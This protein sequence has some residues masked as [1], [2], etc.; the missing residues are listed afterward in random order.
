MALLRPYIPIYV[1]QIIFIRRTGHSARFLDDG[2][3]VLPVVSRRQHSGAGIGSASDQVRSGVEI[4]DRFLAKIHA[5]VVM[6][7]K[8]F[9][10][11]T[12]S[13]PV[14]FESSAGQK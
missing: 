6:G 1:N 7:N 10:K 5:A 12:E 8:T 4:A 13:C 11:S 14:A 9:T 3:G 2:R